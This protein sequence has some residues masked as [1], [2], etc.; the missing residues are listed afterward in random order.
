[1]WVDGAGTGR[2]QLHSAER[3]RRAGAKRNAAGPSLQGRDPGFRDSVHERHGFRPGSCCSSV[4]HCT[5]LTCTAATRMSAFMDSDP[6]GAGAIAEAAI[7]AVMGESSVLG[8]S[9][10]QGGMMSA[11]RD[12][13]RAQCESLG[14]SGALSLLADM[15]GRDANIGFVRE[16][17]DETL[18]KEAADRDAEQ[19]RLTLA[20]LEAAQLSARTSNEA[21]NASKKSAKWTAVAAFA[22]AVSAAIPLIQTGIS[23]FKSCN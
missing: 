21:A 12:G 19:Q 13:I 23:V 5:V 22:A 1:M 20:S 14:V 18:R 8:S 7:K 4:T 17:I 9:F 6:G 2:E 11:R 3:H 10:L 15:E 16:W